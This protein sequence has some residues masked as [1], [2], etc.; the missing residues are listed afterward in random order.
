MF[1]NYAQWCDRCDAQTMH[2]DMDSFSGWNCKYCIEEYLAWRVREPIF[3]DGWCN[4]SR[5]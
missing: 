3:W 2:L 5:N 4:K 1:G